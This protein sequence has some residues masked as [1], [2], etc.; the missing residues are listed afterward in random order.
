[1]QVIIV[2]NEGGIKEGNVNEFL[3]LLLNYQMICEK[4][5]AT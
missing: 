4:N 5:I 1:M 2:K 3:K